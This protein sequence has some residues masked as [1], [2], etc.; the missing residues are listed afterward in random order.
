MALVLHSVIPITIVMEHP[1]YPGVKQ[2]T[3]T[4][5]PALRPVPAKP[6]LTCME[7]VL[8]PAHLTMPRIHSVVAP[9]QVFGLTVTV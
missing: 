9:V 1:V 7:N 4:T 5:V 2:V 6:P 3:P 8:L